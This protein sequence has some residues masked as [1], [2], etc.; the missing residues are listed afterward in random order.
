MHSASSLNKMDTNIEQSITVLFRK[1]LLCWWMKNT[2]R[3]R[4]GGR[5]PKQ[6]SSSWTSLPSWSETCTPST[7]CSYDSSTTTGTALH[8]NSWPA[9]RWGRKSDTD[10]YLVGLDGFQLVANCADVPTGPGGWKS[11]VQKPRSCSGWWPRFSS[12]GPSLT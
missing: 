10:A 4:G 8:L 3:R 9:A 1:Q 11:R 6:N 12:S 7:L 2:A 5:C